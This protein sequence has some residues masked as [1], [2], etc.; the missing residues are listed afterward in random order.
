MFREATDDTFNL[1]RHVVK[2][3]SDSPFFAEI[4]RHV[5]K[6]VTR[7]LPTAGVA[8]DKFTDDFVMGVNPDFFGGLTDE[9]IAGVLRHEFYHIVFYHVTSRRRTPF[10]RWNVATDLA[11]NTIIL[12]P[13]SGKLALPDSALVPGRPLKA[14]PGK[15]N[16][17]AQKLSDLIAS[18]PPMESSDFYWDRLSKL[19]EELQDGCPQHGKGAKSD[20][21]E[22][23]EGS[24]GE[25]E[26]HIHGPSDQECTCGGVGSLDDHSGWDDLTDEERE[27]AEA[28][29]RSILEKGAK[30]ADQHSNGWGSMPASVRDGIRQVISRK[31]D[32]KAVL[33]Q[34][35]G[36]IARGGRTASIRRINR[37]YPYIHP[38]VKRGY[39]AKLAVAVDESGSVSNEML[40]AFFGELENLTKNIA[41][42]VIPFDYTVEEKDV[43]EW[44]KGMK[45]KIVR[46][47]QGGTTFDAATEYVN[48]PKNRGRWDGIIYLTDGQA[49]APIPSRV[50]R[51][52]ILG[53]GCQLA[54]PSGEMQVSMEKSVPP[55]GAWR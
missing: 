53:E 29:A 13:E 28:K 27:Y 47:K 24:H 23:T 54:F 7:D 33:R 31:V 45:P 8:Y 44:R 42:T 12:A 16:A 41:V 15:E 1:D 6:V 3:L 19:A 36:S 9:E 49:P 5:R 26:D 20:T 34:F 22:K 51:G 30:A 52:W 50:K 17:A 11:I 35:V 2:L 25:G 48:S 37:K 18:L 40:G 38:G 46:C 39:V 32:W 14:G 21:S 43:F 4:S 55:K 10:M